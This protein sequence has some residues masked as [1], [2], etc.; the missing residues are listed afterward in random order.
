M[1]I[2]DSMERPDSEGR[3]CGRTKI[4]RGMTAAV[5]LFQ[6]LSDDE[7]KLVEPLIPPASAAATNAPVIIAMVVNGLMYILPRLS[8]ASHP[9]DLPPRSTLYDYFV[10]R[11]DR[12]FAKGSV[13]V[14]KPAWA[15]DPPPVT[16]THSP[17]EHELTKSLAPSRE[18]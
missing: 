14:G 11:C 7:W 15:N 12:K 4:A 8:M 10:S 18:I 17:L 3:R 1:I 9:K 2:C 6:R 16:K 5:A 13:Q